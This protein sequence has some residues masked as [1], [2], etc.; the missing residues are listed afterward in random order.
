MT[1]YE[2]VR[3]FHRKMGHPLDQYIEDDGELVLLREHL[4][5]EEFDEVLSFMSKENL[6]KEL[7]D[8]LYVTYGYAATFGLNIDEAFNR[9]HESNL[10]KLGD[11]GKPVVREDG[12][13]LKGP[14]YK[15]PDL[16]DLV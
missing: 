14:N 6:L 16:G 4:L 11:D 15:A 2:K 9:V 7:A 1:N 3:E 5:E 8:L 10:S 12:K 13:I